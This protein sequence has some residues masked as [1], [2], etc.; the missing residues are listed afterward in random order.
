MYKEFR[1]VTLNGAVSQ[2]CKYFIPFFII[3]FFSDQEMSGNHRADAQ[4][5][6]II[7][8]AVLNKADQVKRVKSIAFRVSFIFFIKTSL[9]VIVSF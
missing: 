4:A 2:L 3:S 9:I 8:T 7:R 5:I 6:H 1:D